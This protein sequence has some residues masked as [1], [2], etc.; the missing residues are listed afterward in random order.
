MLK[1]ESIGREEVGG[2]GRDIG[3]ERERER[4]RMRENGR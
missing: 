4:D 1:I 3:K 2:S